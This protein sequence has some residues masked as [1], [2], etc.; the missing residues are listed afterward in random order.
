MCMWCDSPATRYCDAV[1]GVEAIT[2]SRGHR[3]AVTA[4]LTSL[5]AQQW[6]CDAPMCDDHAR[7][8]GHICGAEPDS[9]DHCPHHVVAKRERMAALM[10]ASDE[11]QA[12][13]REIH[14]GIRRAR[15]RVSA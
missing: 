4:R 12:R 10:M 14:A 6:T 11:A 8:V 2:A 7:R 15:L 9:I 1:I 5:D 3:G 13:R